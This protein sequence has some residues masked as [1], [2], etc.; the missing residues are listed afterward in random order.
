M[1]KI[2]LWIFCNQKILLNAFKNLQTKKLKNIEVER[3]INE[4]AERSVEYVFKRNI[5][6][7]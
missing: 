7:L 3:L 2:V 6:C 4:Y 5:G 1:A